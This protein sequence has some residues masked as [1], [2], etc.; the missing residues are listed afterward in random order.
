[1]SRHTDDSSDSSSDD[2]PSAATCFQEQARYGRDRSRMKKFP[3][4][5][6]KERRCFNCYS[7]DYIMTK[8]KKPYDA[9]RANSAAVKYFG[10]CSDKLKRIKA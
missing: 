5:K 9:V 2:G 4:Q 3:V 8:C 6:R 10:K 7:K 1:M